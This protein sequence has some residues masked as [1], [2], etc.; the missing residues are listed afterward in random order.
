VY[1]VADGQMSLLQGISG[2]RQAGRLVGGW[3]DETQE[4]LDLFGLNMD[5]HGTLR[6]NGSEDFL[7][8]VVLGKI[9]DKL[10]KIQDGG[11][12]PPKENE[13]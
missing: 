7:L 8:S 1:T 10:V 12:P 13:K 11:N 6:R 5:R 3:M 9:P 2:G 4:S